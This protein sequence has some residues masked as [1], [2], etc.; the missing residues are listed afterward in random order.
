VG[1]ELGAEDIVNGQG[2]DPADLPIL[3]DIT[4]DGTEKNILQCQFGDHG[5]HTHQC[6][7]NE[8]AGVR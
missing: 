5:T 3:H 4:C 1:Y 7:G 8:K 6:E 2:T